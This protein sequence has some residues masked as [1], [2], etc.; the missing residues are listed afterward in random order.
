MISNVVSIV[1]KG[2]VEIRNLLLS[3]M[4]GYKVERRQERPIQQCWEGSEFRDPKEFWRIWWVK[5]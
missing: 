2:P 1:D 4:S 5:M 3:D